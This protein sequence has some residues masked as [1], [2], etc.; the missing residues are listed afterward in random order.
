MSFNLEERKRAIQ[1]GMDF[2]CRTAG[3]MKSW[4]AS[5]PYFFICFPLIAA[6]SKSITLRKMARERGRSLALRWQSLC[7]A[8]PNKPRPEV[9][10]R[11]LLGGYTA[12]H[13]G[14]RNEVLREQ[15]RLAARCFS[16][17]EF[18]GFD[19][20]SEPPPDNVSEACSC[21]LENVPGRKR[22]QRCRKKLIINSRY[23][24]WMGA[25]GTTFWADRYGVTL[26]ARYADVLQWLPNMRPYSMH[27]KQDYLAFFD[28]VYAVTH[29]VY[30]LNGYGRYNLSSRWLPQEFEFLR[31]NVNVAIRWDDPDMVGEFL[32]CLKAFGLPNH[33]PTIRLATNYLLAKQNADGSWGDMQVN[34]IF[35][36]FHATWTAVD[37]LREYA[38]RGE[39]LSYPSLQPL[40]EQFSKRR[41][42]R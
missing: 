41:H 39:R 2:L 14:L 3:K 32:D 28:I 21:G 18:L 15:V 42:S 10:Y 31:A 27:Q 34:D 23:R 20:R 6:T 11:F 30:T 29:L 4:R 35:Q 16:A 12:D 25:L 38:W 1:M 8:L 22:C 7:P 5:G 19:P 33:H 9:V 24:V 17:R 40:L 13:F 37:G 26:G 36:R